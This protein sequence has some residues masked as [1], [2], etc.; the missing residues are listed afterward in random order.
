MREN[1]TVIHVFENLGNWTIP[2]DQAKVRLVI[3][4]QTYR[5]Q[6]GKRIPN[7]KSKNLVFCYVLKR[8]HDYHLFSIHFG[9]LAEF[10]VVLEKTKKQTII[11]FSRKTLDSLGAFFFLNRIYCI[12]AHRNR[13]LGTVIRCFE[14]WKPVENC[15]DQSDYCEPYPRKPG[16]T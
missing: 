2:S 3:L 9:A 8:L 1:F 15:S 4:K 12:G 6:Q 5:V 14:A 10:K 7:W 16:G 11:E 13:H